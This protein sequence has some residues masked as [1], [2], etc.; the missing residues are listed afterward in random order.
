MYSFHLLKFYDFFLLTDGPCSLDFSK[1]KTPDNSYNDPTAQELVQRHRIYSGAS[2]HSNVHVR[3]NDKKLNGGGSPQRR[4]LF[5]RTSSSSSSASK[6]SPSI[7]GVPMAAREHVGALYQGGDGGSQLLFGK[8]N[9]SL[10]VVSMNLFFFNFTYK[11]G[12]RT[13]LL[14]Q[15]RHYTLLFM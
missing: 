13:A 5:T 8:N 9:V 14:K 7:P 12:L 6:L 10:N 15:Y 2:P 1:M 4:Q 3:P 11:W